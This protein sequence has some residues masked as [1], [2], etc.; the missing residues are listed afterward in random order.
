MA[1]WKLKLKSNVVTL[2]NAPDIQ[3]T[4]VWW[5]QT[6]C[7]CTGGVNLV[8]PGKGIASEQVRQHCDKTC[9]PK[10]PNVHW[11]AANGSSF[12]FF[13]CSVHSIGLVADS[14]SVQSAWSVLAVFS[15]RP[16]TCTVCQRLLAFW[17]NLFCADNF[18][19]LFCNRSVHSISLLFLSIYISI[20]P[21][22]SVLAI[23]SY[24]CKAC[25]GQPVPTAGRNFFWMP[26]PGFIHR[27]KVGGVHHASDQ[28]VFAIAETAQC[29]VGC[30]GN[31][32]IQHHSHV[33]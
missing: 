22:C 29:R 8:E 32:C 10:A 20:G 21:T 3:E 1:E 13:F 28:V 12:T 23:S 15:Y 24:H 25:C 30:P 14:W 11:H 4:C 27:L 33:R 31:L 16:R 5:Q 18:K 19:L 6:A 2:P 9:M 7:S 26:L 17:A